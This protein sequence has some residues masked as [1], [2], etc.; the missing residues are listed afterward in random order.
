[1]PR[2]ALVSPYLLHALAAAAVLLGLYLSR[3]Y[4]YVL[5]HTLV[6]MFSV[7][8]ACA[9][10]MIAWNTRRFLTNNYILFIGITFL[11]VS[12]LDVLHTLSFKGLNIVQGFDA[13]LPTQLWIAAR[14]MGSISLLVAPLVMDWKPRP[15]LLFWL[16]T[17]ATAMVLASIFVWRI[18]P[19]CYIDG[20]GLTKF[21]IVSEYVISLFFATALVLLVW[22]RDEFERSVLLL[23]S[24]SILLRVASEIMFTQYEGVY[25]TPNMIGH[26]FKIAAFYLFYKALIESAL[27]KPYLMLF[28]NLKRSEEELREERDRVQNYLDV[29]KTIL[30]VIDADERV[31]LINRMG[32]EVMGYAESEIVGRN[33]FDNFIPAGIREDVRETFRKLMAGLVAP[34]EYFENPVLTR[35]GEERI[36]AWHNAVLRDDRDRIIATLSSGEDIT[37]RR[38][39]EEALARKTKE[40]ERSNAELE[41]FASVVS[42]DLKEPLMTIGGFA[43]I[44]RERYALA[45]D[46]KGREHVERIFDGALRMER[47]VSD[48]LAF[49]RVATRGSAFEPV[50]LEG[51]VGTVLENL[52]LSIDECGAAVTADP[53][54]IVM[55]DE[56][57]LIQLFQNLIG[58]ALKYRRDEPP[59]IH[60]SARPAAE[61]V[62]RSAECEGG[63]TVDT[64]W[65]VAVSDNGI[66][67]DPRHHEIIFKIFERL[68][69]SDKYPGTGIGLAICKKIVERHGG[70]IWVESEPGKGSTFYFTIQ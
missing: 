61:Y 60:I 20:E 54:P 9:I 38:E 7:I 63:A 48:L 43:E 5:M 51:V 35:S 6:E 22:K 67:I 15:V 37:A 46:R 44:L 27:V 34:V 31:S 42:H 39:T 69:K 53:L 41:Q 21:K 8:V 40:L 11:F 18:F 12:V 30:V 14:Y 68:H 28:R 50:R 10:F 45:L 17:A 36:I 19:D 57:Q 49:A 23:L 47:L 29:A 24:G 58:N 52:K 2:R 62:V 3:L 55:G 25:D 59:R 64:G 70:C 13:N 32:S 26:F 4:S 1:M 33:W 66:G 16:C 65:V 56:T